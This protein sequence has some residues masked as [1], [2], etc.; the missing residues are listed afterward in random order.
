MSDWEK[1]MAEDL[2]RNAY[3]NAELEA[4]CLRSGMSPVRVPGIVQMVRSALGIKITPDFRVEGPRCQE[5]G[6]RAWLL[7][8]EP[9][10]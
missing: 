1:E 6:Y 8:E 9:T 4:E 5:E 2:V 10:P 3:I 7:E